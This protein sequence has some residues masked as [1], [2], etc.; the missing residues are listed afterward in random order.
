M[1][2]FGRIDRLKVKI[3]CGGVYY[4][5]NPNVVC[6]VVLVPCCTVDGGTGVVEGSAVDGKFVVWCCDDGWTVACVVVGLFV[7]IWVVS[8]IIKH[9]SLLSLLLFHF[10]YSD[11]IQLNKLIM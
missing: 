6:C 8:L 2:E 3:V 7:I 1:K 11:H 4:I 5:P 10:I 9:C